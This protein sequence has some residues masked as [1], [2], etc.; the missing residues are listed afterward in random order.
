[1]GNGEQGVLTGHKGVENTIPL[2]IRVARL[3]L[4]IVVVKSYAALPFLHSNGVTL[5]LSRSIGY[6]T[7]GIRPGERFKIQHRAAAQLTFW[8]KAVYWEE[9]KNY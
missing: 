1:M 7:R 9:D 3:V 2:M 8:T 4:I 6:I 5:G